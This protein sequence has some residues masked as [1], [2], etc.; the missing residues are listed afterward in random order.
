MHTASPSTSVVPAG[1]IL[2][3]I[4]VHKSGTTAIQAAFE[5]ARPSLAQFGVV[6]PG[7]QQAHR[8]IASSAMGRPLGWRTT[9]AL[10]PDASAWN[11]FVRTAHSYSGITVCSSE[12]FAESDDRTAAAIVERVGLDRIHV[13]LTLRNLGRILPSAWQQML[14]SGFEMDYSRWLTDIL[15]T[16]PEQM[17]PKSTTFWI[18]HRHGDVVRRWTE[19]VGPER[20][21]VIVVDDQDREAIYSSFEQ[22]LGMPVGA[23]LEYRDLSNNR[24]MT[25]PEAELIRALNVA[26]GGGKGWKP[27]SQQQ[28]DSMIKAITEGRQAPAGE[29]R[30][31]TP[32]WA[33]DIAAELAR[34]D[35]NTIRALGVRVIG[36]LDLLAEH[37]TSPDEMAESNTDTIPVDAAVAAILG[38]MNPVATPTPDVSLVERSRKKVSSIMKRNS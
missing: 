31:L 32:Q 12:F 29:A 16:P 27:Y 22:L 5:N 14:K 2:L 6:Y 28:H 24:S 38:A 9:G 3:H 19:L 4:G 8:A 26:V 33:L 17:H 13:V 1:G 21:T 35:V 23:L 10:K 7:E 18:R 34:E 11:D 30:L 20:L 25:A 36:D 15:V 37:L